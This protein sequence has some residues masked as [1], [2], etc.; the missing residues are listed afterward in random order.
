VEAAGIPT[1]ALANL[2]TPVLR[3]KYPRAALVRHPRGGTV[4]EPGDAESQ[5]RFLRQTLALLKDAP[6]PAHVEILNSEWKGT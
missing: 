5:L 3:M 1:V 2:R 6:D 4:G